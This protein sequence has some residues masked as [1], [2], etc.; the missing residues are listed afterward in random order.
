MLNNSAGIIGKAGQRI[1][2]EHRGALGGQRRRGQR[3]RPIPPQPGA[4][5]ER[6]YPGVFQQASQRRARPEGGRGIAPAL[7]GGAGAMQTFGLRIVDASQHDR[8]EPGGVFLQGSGRAAECHQPRPDPQRAPRR[9]PCRA[10]LAHTAR[11]DQGVAVGIFVVVAGFEQPGG[12]GMYTAPPP[13]KFHGGARPGFGQANIHNAHAAAEIRTLCQIVPGTGGVKRHRQIGKD[14][15]FGGRQ[16]AAAVHAK[17]GWRVHR[18]DRNEA[19][20]AHDR[21]LGQ[22]PQQRVL[23]RPVQPGSEH[24]IDGQIAP[25]ADAVAARIEFED[26]TFVPGLDGGRAAIVIHPRIG[27]QLFG[28][29]IEEHLHLPAPLREQPGDD[30]SVAAIVARSAKNERLAA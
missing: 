17:A 29:A 15:R 10:A 23:R 3:A 6:I 5:A 22:Q 8:V 4:E 16:R 25:A 30:E 9:Q 26:C 12:P 11:Q 27:R 20:P 13:Q 19:R 24:R 18:K 14:C 28:I 21:E 2:V 1:G 7:G